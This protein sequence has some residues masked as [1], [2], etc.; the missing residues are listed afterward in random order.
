MTSL[1]MRGRYLMRE[2]W[3]DSVLQT[4]LTAEER[5]LLIALWML[6]DDE[7]WMPRNVTEIAGAAFQFED[8]GPREAKVR[9]GLRRL[10]DIGKV[11]SLRCGCLFVP[12][13]VKY[14]RAGKKSDEHARAHREHSKPIKPVQTHSDGFEV[15]D[16]KHQTDLN[17]SPVPSLPDPSSAR[18][19][20]RDGSQSDGAGGIEA[21]RAVIER[22]PA[23]A[24]RR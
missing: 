23:P 6:A 16:S 24:G 12:A 13:V 8:R 10:T 1:T 4:R 9:S 20:A 18:A 22:I 21:V 3:S 19:P 7:G 2:Y 5:E 15:S 17:A 14:P 11:S